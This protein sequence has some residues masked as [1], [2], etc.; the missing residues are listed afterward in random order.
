MTMKFIVL[1]DLHLGRPGQAVNGLDP[2]VRLREAITTI[3]RDHFD[4]RFVLLAGDLADTGDTAAYRTLQ[5][6]IAEIKVPTHITLGNHDNRDNFL[7]IM[8]PDFDHPE[9]RVSRVIDDGGYRIILL[10]TSEPGL[11]GGRLCLG[12]K[13]WLEAKLK[14]ASDRPVIIVMH[15]HANKLSLPVDVIA[16]EDS[17]G[18]AHILSNHSDIRLVLSGHVHITTTGM[19][20]GIPVATLAGCHYSVSPHLPGMQGEQ[21]CLEG[22]AQMAVILADEESVTVH[23]HDYVQRYAP[24]ARGLFR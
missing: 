12:R 5:D 23:F 17:S 19:W 15:H 10:D 7:Q 4:A 8:G 1:S 21:V 6:M 11:I 2:E 3:N 14:E 20:R 18:F 9:A 24:L 16:L 13:A 22:P